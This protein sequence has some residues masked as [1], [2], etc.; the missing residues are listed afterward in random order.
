[1][2]HEGK[3]Y[4]NPK[5]STIKVFGQVGKKYSTPQYEIVCSVC[6][7]DQEL[8]GEI[9]A[10]STS[11]L[12]CTSPCGCTRTPR[13]TESQNIIR[14]KRYLSALGYSYEG[15]AEKYK[16]KR[17]KVKIF[18]PETGNLWE[19]TTIENLLLGVRDPNLSGKGSIAFKVNQFPYTENFT[20]KP[21]VSGKKYFWDIYCNLCDISFELYQSQAKRG[22]VSCNCAHNKVTSKDQESKLAS[23]LESS[24][25]KLVGSFTYNTSRSP[26]TWVCEEGH[27]NTTKY[28]N[29]MNG[30][31][32]STCAKGGYS[33]QKLGRFYIVRWEG[34]GESYLK[35][36]I[37]N[38]EVLQRISEQD[39]A[40]AHL[41]Y[42]ILHEFYH[43]DG[44][45]AADC[46][47]YLMSVMETEVC[48]K[49]LLPDGYTE[50]C[51]DTQ[52]NID[53]ILSQVDKFGLKSK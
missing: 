24:G 38:R 7:E 16:G 25:F 6:S 49:Q 26:V 37:T 39:T 21:T 42:T 12:K 10:P 28:Y 29:I 13:W 32:C 20:I 11:I 35:F 3:L 9:L 34:Y 41:D 30:K 36:G 31:G 33:K 14:I 44:N 27:K 51:H 17:T 15:W 8:W 22:V 47:K 23:K 19:T 45:V 43:E 5:G 2:K 46:E 4:V 40:S 53:L 52:Q 50:T 18:N 48:T 1:M